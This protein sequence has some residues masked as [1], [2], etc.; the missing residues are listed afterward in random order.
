MF[1]L[2]FRR[3]KRLADLKKLAGIRMPE[4]AVAIALQGDDGPIVDALLDFV[5][6]LVEEENTERFRILSSKAIQI[7]T[8]HRGADVAA[9][10]GGLIQLSASPRIDDTESPTHRVS[11]VRDLAQALGNSARIVHGRTLTRVGVVG[12]ETRKTWGYFP[13]EMGQILRALLDA[14]PGVPVDL[15]DGTSEDSKAR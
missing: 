9:N 3:E 15:G 10:A 8:E 5:F 6:L 11:L 4:S 2:N 14:T 12:I 7:A 1:W 13:R